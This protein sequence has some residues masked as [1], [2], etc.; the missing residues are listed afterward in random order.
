[1]SSSVL[2]IDDSLTVRMDLKSAFE[3]GGYACTLAATLA[4]GRAALRDGIFNLIVLDVQLPDGDGVSFLSELKATIET[5]AIPVIMLSLEADVRARVRGL[6]TGADEYVGKPYDKRYLLGCADELIRSRRSDPAVHQLPNL[7]VIDPSETFRQWLKQLVEP[8]GYHMVEGQSGAQGLRLTA[9]IQPAAIVVDD[10]MTGIDGLTFISRIKSNSVLREIPC[11]FFTD[12]DDPGTEIRAL[13][14]GV[15]AFMRKREDPAMLLIRLGALTHSREAMRATDGAKSLFGNKKL[16]GIGL[17]LSYLHRLA[18]EL[19]SDDYEMAIAETVAEALQLLAVRRADCILIESA[20]AAGTFFRQIRDSPDWRT[21]PLIVLADDPASATVREALSA[22]VD[23]CVVKSDDFAVAKAQLRNLLRRKQVADRNRQAREVQL[24]DE[25]RAAAAE[26]LVMGQLAETRARLLAE[27]ETKNTELVGARETALEALRIKS[28]FMMNMSH[29]IR[30]PLN[31]ILGMTELLLET[32]LTDEQA[33][34]ARTVSVSG[35]LLL[36]IVN[37]I[38]DFTKLDEGKV[39]FEQID[40]D[41]AGVLE[42]T[43]ELFA[44]EAH[45]K[46]IE[47]M[48]EYGSE[49]STTISG[50]AYRLRQVLNNLLG[51]AMKFTHA[52]EVILRVAAAAQTADEASFRFEVR[53]TGIG[54][55]PEAQARL[56]VPFSQADASTTRKYGGTGLGLTISKKLVERMRGRIE[57]ES[58][59]GKGSSFHFTAM[60][61]RPTTAA[62]AESSDP[63]LQGMLALIVDDNATNR[64]VVAKTLLSWGMVAESAASGA[65]SLAAMRRRAAENRPYQ[66]VIIDAEMPEMDGPALAR[67][68]RSDPALLNTPLWLMNPVGDSATSGAR[69]RKDFDGCVTKPVR[70]SDLHKSLS[71]LLEPG[72]PDAGQSAHG[73]AQPALQLSSASA[74]HAVA[75]LRVLVVDDNLVNLKV[76]ERQLRKLGYRVDLAGGGKAAIEALFNT[77]YTVVLL[78]CEMPEMDGYDTVAEIRRRENNRRHTIV[79]AMTAHALEG[80]RLRCLDAGMDEYI[81]KPVS[82]Q[83]LTAVLERCALLETSVVGSPLSAKA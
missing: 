63:R 26:A 75:P 83:A 38:L 47:L 53:D 79:V 3:T 68:V 41:L 76:A 7:L 61:A 36:N 22:G 39:V 64:A 37:D 48:L 12:S 19:L 31:G 52:G 17:D 43:I 74:N 56:F 32:D 16:L 73:S 71:A 5:R 20:S 14:A 9:E 66:V 69:R 15:D 62:P 13:E 77:H 58:V 45:S 8:N 44:K 40:F 4:A 27:L 33:E 10:Q 11:V 67:T 50:D 2:V 72:S 6:T 34:F 1:M 80:A 21:I 28:E 78:D 51:N 23:D 54:I 29:E 35:T 60:F 81:A 82:L 65:L 25:T 42:S 30:T 57:I 18:G 55:P 59:P 49:V 70:P 24:R 46:G